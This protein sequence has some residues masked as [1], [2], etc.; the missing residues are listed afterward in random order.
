MRTIYVAV[1]S[2]RGPKIAGAKR[3]VELI[4][5]FLAP[6]ASFEVVGA[7]VPSG[8]RHTPL[9]RAD[10]MAGARHRTEA[11]VQLGRQRNEPWSYFV[12]VEGGLDTVCEGG[13][14]IVLLESWACVLDAAGRGRF[15]RSGGIELPAALAAK[16]VDGGVE[17]GVAMDELTGQHGIRDA[18]GAW[19]VLSRNLVT[20]QDAFE[21]AVTAAFAPFF[22]AQVYRRT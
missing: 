13:R 11:L 15:G 2:T 1:G 6:E 3:A 10:G 9:T 8:V 22:N 17:L 18:Q 12:G 14:R 7:D 5:P 4:A 19:G 20:R 16:V 21:T